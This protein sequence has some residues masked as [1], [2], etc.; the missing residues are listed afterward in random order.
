MPP[1]RVRWAATTED[2]VRALIS[3][4]SF[5]ES[6][7]LDAKR[8]TGTSPGARRETA[9]DLASFAIDGG[10]LLIGVD[11]DKPSG[12]FSLAPQPLD[13]LV[14][15]LEQIAATLVDPPL[16]IRVDDIPSD[17]ASRAGYLLVTIP[18]SPL[19]PHMADGRYYARGERTKRALSDAEVL[20]CLL[21]TSDAADE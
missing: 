7:H 13:G 3:D 21:Y 19:A 9:R 5:K 10:Q 1:E 20:R 6:H 4:G 18:P 2:E 8:E 17:D 16:T 12:T 15:K 11:E 14:E